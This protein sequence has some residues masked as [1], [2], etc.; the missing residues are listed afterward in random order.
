MCGGGVAV[1]SLFSAF[2]HVNL[3]APVCLLL[4]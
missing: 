1:A 4:F 3:S 2:L